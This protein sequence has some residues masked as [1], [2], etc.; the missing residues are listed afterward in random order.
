MHSMF[1]QKA[2]IVVA[3][4]A[5]ASA[6]FLDKDF[7]LQH[8]A[9]QALA[10]INDYRTLHGSNLTLAQQMTLDLSEKIVQT[11]S[12]DELSGLKSICAAAFPDKLQCA[13]FIGDGSSAEVTSRR[14]NLKRA[15]DCSCNTSSDY[16]YMRNNDLRCHAGDRNGMCN[17]SHRKPPDESSSKHVLIVH[18][19]LLH[20]V[21]II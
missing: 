13:N 15:P 10:R 3:T 16:C 19:L 1:L 17:Y 21:L 11:F 12:I 4:A 6:E 7:Y 9:P 20:T 8:V 2:L 5:I 14:S 18:M